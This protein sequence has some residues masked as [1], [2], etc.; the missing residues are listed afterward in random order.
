MHY[1]VAK[2][3]NGKED[4]LVTTDDVKVANNIANAV[5]R[6]GAWNGDLFAVWSRVER[7]NPEEA[8]T[9]VASTS[10][11]SIVVFSNGALFVLDDEY[12]S[13]VK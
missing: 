12:L 3:L 11:V 2:L 10:P 1:I 6:I 8:A 5:N 7:P 13:L 9:L 4:E